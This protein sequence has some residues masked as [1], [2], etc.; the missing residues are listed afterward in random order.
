MPKYNCLLWFIFF[1]NSAIKFKIWRRIRSETCHFFKDFISISIYLLTKQ[2]EEAIC[3]N[4][5]FCF[6]SQFF[7]C[8]S[9]DCSIWFIKKSSSQELNLH[10][11]AEVDSKSRCQ[12][13]YIICKIIGNFSMTLEMC[14]KKK[15]CS[16]A[17]GCLYG[18]NH[19]LF[20][21]GPYVCVLHTV[22]S[23]VFF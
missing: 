2:I 23:I 5:K 18:Q 8:I 16:P 13:V 4:C 6:I 1:L 22:F 12:L 21:Y 7:K 17:S 14:P 19:G 11:L 15:Y 3:L 9:H 10:C 20:M